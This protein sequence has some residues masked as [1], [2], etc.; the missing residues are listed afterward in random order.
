MGNWDSESRKFKAGRVTLSQDPERTTLSAKPRET[1]QVH[2]SNTW[3]W[4]LTVLRKS[5]GL[6]DRQTKCQPGK[7]SGFTESW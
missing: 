4:G 6:A 3:V 1:A 5:Q 7:I 2:L